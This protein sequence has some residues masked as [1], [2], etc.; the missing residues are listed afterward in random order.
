MGLKAI[1]P[2][3]RPVRT[4][5]VTQRAWSGTMSIGTLPR[6]LKPVVKRLAMVATIE[7]G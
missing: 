6:V 2:G 4:R 3:H 5:S 7:M 1:P